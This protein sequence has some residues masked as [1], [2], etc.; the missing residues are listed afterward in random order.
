MFPIT[1]SWIHEHI[2]IYYHYYSKSKKKMKRI[3]T[4]AKLIDTIRWARVFSLT[5]LDH[6]KY[7]IVYV[8]F[9]YS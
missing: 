8:L 4:V 9:Y 3:E 5:I 2:Y 1:E 7:Y 6:A